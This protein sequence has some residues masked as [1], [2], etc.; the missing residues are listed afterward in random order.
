MKPYLKIFVHFIVATML[1]VGCSAPPD[2]ITVDGVEKAISDSETAA[3]A[4]DDIQ[5][6][7][8]VLSNM[9]ER[10]DATVQGTHSALLIAAN[11]PPVQVKSI[12]TAMLQPQFFS[13]EALV[14]AC[15]GEKADQ[16]VR[17]DG[18]SSIV[19][20][21]L[22]GTTPM[23]IAAQFISYNNGEFFYVNQELDTMYSGEIESDL[24]DAPNC[25]ITREQ[26][27]R[28]AKEY[29]AGLGVDS[30][31]VHTVK[32]KV[33]DQG[34]GKGFYVLSFTTEFF[35]IPFAGSGAT[36]AGLNSPRGNISISDQG[37]L[38][39]SGNFMFRAID[40]APVEKILSIDDILK[41]IPS[42]M[43]K[44]IKT[45]ADTPVEEIS[46]RY[47]V[48]LNE[49]HYPQLIPV[50]VFDINQDKAKEII[51]DDEIYFIRAARDIIFNAITG[52]LEVAG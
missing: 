27:M 21:R 42:M 18:E 31:Y 5:D 20:Y 45:Q 28:T 43:D 10:V 2:R 51:Q 38:T 30:I 11:V 47:I 16:A 35:G 26:A 32:S 13:E 17:V 46:L 52:Q 40:A 14:G 39:I 44:K 36:T 1:T 49:N 12:F 34:N 7:A 29:L 41:L 50:W 23:G 48:K 6:T 33:S 4:Q 25:G 24:V 3:I 15:F 22:P 37:I 19:E 9:P 8:E